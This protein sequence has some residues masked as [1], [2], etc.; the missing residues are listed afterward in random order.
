MSFE[1]F[2]G[3][4]CDF[5]ANEMILYEELRDRYP[6]LFDEATSHKC[7]I[8][9]PPNESLPQNITKAFIE[10]HVLKPSPFFKEQYVTMAGQDSTVE[11]RDNQYLITIGTG[12]KYCCKLQILKLETV[13]STSS[14]RRDYQICF[15]D[16]HFFTVQQQLGA[17]RAQASPAQGKDTSMGNVRAPSQSKRLHG[18]SAG[19]IPVPAPAPTRRQLGTPLSRAS[20]SAIEQQLKVRLSECVAED[21]DSFLQSYVLLPGNCDATAERVQVLFD[22]ACRVVLKKM[23]EDIARSQKNTEAV[24]CTAACAAME[25]LHGRLWPYWVVEHRTED[26]ALQRSMSIVRKYMPYEQVIADTDAASSPFL[27]VDP[28]C[29]D[30]VKV[31]LQRMYE[32]AGPLAY[33]ETMSSVLEKIRGVLPAE[34]AEGLCAD[35][36]LPALV[37]VLSTSGAVSLESCVSYVMNF[38]PDALLHSS[39]GYALTTFQ[40]AVGAVLQLAENVEAEMGGNVEVEEEDPASSYTPVSVV[41]SAVRRDGPQPSVDRKASMRQPNRNSR[42]DAWTAKE[43]TPVRD[44]TAARDAAATLKNKSARP[45]CIST[46]ETKD[47][48]DFL[49]SL[50]DD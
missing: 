20:V 26:A 34:D 15:V 50:L 8:V 36:M 46:H 4:E 42:D 47:V 48:G 29:F 6:S 45:T 7:I 11:N 22:E 9:L 17:M 14:A 49:S 23:P 3:D 37:Y 38:A 12:W 1:A 18:T 30:K 43:S 5:N 24:H 40:A 35:D 33:M 39:L 19:H 44:L 27:K 28:Q 32:D 10:H 31:V 41:P 13:H 16:Q 21:C 2:G 25:C